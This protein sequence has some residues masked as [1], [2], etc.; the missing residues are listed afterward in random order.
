MYGVSP[1]QYVQSRRLKKAERI[2]STVRDVPLKVVAMD[3]GFSD[4]SHMTRLFQEKLSMTPKQYRDKNV[5]RLFGAL[6][7]Q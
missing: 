6:A 5:S 4:Q 1:H 2:L 7:Y 3:C